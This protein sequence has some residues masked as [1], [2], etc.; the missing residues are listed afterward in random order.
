M[1]NLF[2]CVS[3][4]FLL[5]LTTSATL[6]ISWQT[7]CRVDSGSITRESGT[8]VFR[9]SKNHCTGGIFNQRAELN[10]GN[11][12]ISR[13]V[14]YVFDTTISMKAAAREEFIVFQVHDGRMGCSPPMS[15]RWT[16]GNTLRFD[17]DYTRGKGMAGCVENRSLRGAQ[18]RGPSLKRDGTAYRLQ[19][20][21]TFDGNGGFGVDVLINGKS[22]ISGTYQPSSDPSF[23]ASKRFFM[24]HGVYSKNLFEYEMSSKGMRVSQ[25]Q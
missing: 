18:Y 4:L 6:A 25:G 3:A 16:G 24:K 12:S 15:L 2:F 8:Y 20:K 17:S 19:V 14:T 5:L 11:I 7:S 22:A 21:L 1:K 9:T 10:T 13:K 23:V